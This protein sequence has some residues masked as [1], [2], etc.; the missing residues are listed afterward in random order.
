MD[1]AVY[2]RGE[3]SGD[4]RGK[5]CAT[6][7]C[8]QHPLSTTILPSTR[9]SASRAASCDSAE[10]LSQYHL[11]CRQTVADDPTFRR[12]AGLKIGRRPVLAGRRA[13]AAV[14]HRMLLSSPG[15]DR[16]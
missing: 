11:T 16:A 10:A 3:T 14:R 6:P 13:E 4:S 15:P 1:V 7:A 9:S 8:E 12:P 2:A 5:R